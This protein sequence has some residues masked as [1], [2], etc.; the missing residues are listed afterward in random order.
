ML[1][2]TGRSGLAQT[3]EGSLSTTCFISDFVKGEGLFSSPGQLH[4]YDGEAVGP[5]YPP[6]DVV[7]EAIRTD[8]V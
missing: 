1:P 5:N 2:C 4:C 8:R 7:C 3:L 6:R